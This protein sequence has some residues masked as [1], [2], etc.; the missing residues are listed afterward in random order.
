M[1]S[2]DLSK[3]LLE[4]LAKHGVGG[5][6]SSA[7]SAPAGLGGGQAGGAVASYI[8]E[9]ITGHQAFDSVTLSK[10]VDVLSKGTQGGK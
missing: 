6:P 10:V 2:E 7:T 3:E 9:I 8:K 5:L 4:V 1:A